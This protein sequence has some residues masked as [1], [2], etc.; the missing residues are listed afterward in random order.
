MVTPIAGQ[1]MSNTNTNAAQYT[2]TEY[3][4]QEQANDPFEDLTRDLGLSS[5]EIADMLMRTPSAA[6]S[7]Y[8]VQ[9]WRDHFEGRDLSSR[10][11]ISNF[12]NTNYNL[13][14]KPGWLRIN[15]EPQASAGSIF[16]DNDEKYIDQDFEVQVRL[17]ANN[18]NNNTAGFLYTQS[19]NYLSWFGFFVNSDDIQYLSSLSG[20]G[21]SGP[22]ANTSTAD[23]SSGLDLKINYTVSSA[24]VKYYYRVNSWANNTWMH[25]YTEST[26]ETTFDFGFYT[27]ANPGSGGMQVDLDYFFIDTEQEY[28][29]LNTLRDNVNDYDQV[30]SPWLT[31]AAVH[32]ASVS[33]DGNT[34]V[35]GGGYLLDT[36]LHIY[37]WDYLQRKYV[38]AWEAGSEVIT[39]DVYDI[40]FGDADNNRLQEVAAASADG[41]VYLFEQAHIYDPNT[42]L[43]SKYELVWQSDLI[44][45]QVS[46]VDF[47]DLDLD[48]ITD[49]VVGAWDK[50]VHIYEYTNHSGYPFA[51]AEHWIE[52]TE[53]W[54]SPEL[55]DAVMSVATGDFNNN[56]LPDFVVG[57]WSGHVYV[58]EN[59]GL[60]I[61]VQGTPTQLPWDNNYKMI[62]NSSDALRPLW[63]P[64]SK[65]AAGQ[66]DGTG[67][68][69]AVLLVWGQGSYVLQYTSSRGFYLEQLVKPYRF[70][71]TPDPYPLDNYAD[72]IEHDF[73]WNIYNTYSGSPVDEPKWG[74][75]NGNTNTASSGPPDGTYSIYS[76]SSTV[77]ASTV[78]NM[79]LHNEELAT[80]GNEDPDLFIMFP[81]SQYVQ[82]NRWTIAL[83]K[84][85]E[86]WYEVD[87]SDI[88]FTYGSSYQGK[89]I[90][91]DCD[92]LFAEQRMQSVKYVKLTLSEGSIEHRVDTLF[93]P[94]AAKPLTIASAVSIED[95]KLSTSDIS[96]N[97][98]VFG[99]SDGRF[100]SYKFEDDHSQYHFITGYTD[101][102][103]ASLI[104][105]YGVTIPNYLEV[106]DS[107][108]DDNY[109]LGVTVWDLSRTDKARV[110]PSWRYYADNPATT[111]YYNN[112]QFNGWG[113]VD[114]NDKVHSFSVR[115]I[116]ESDGSLELIINTNSSLDTDDKI[117]LFD[118][119]TGEEKTLYLGWLG[120]I[121]LSTLY[122][123]DINNYYSGGAVN[124]WLTH[125]MGDLNNDDTQYYG[126]ELITFP[127]HRDGRPFLTAGTTTIDQV[128]PRIWTRA[129]SFNKFVHYGGSEAD[130]SLLAYISSDTNASFISFLLNPTTYPSSYIYDLD[131]DNDNDI[132]VSNGHLAVLWNTGTPNNPQFTFDDNYFDEVNADLVG[133]QIF[134][135]QMWDY[136]LDGD[137]DV[138]FSYGKGDGD[139]IWGFDFFMNLGANIRGE[140]H[141]ER[142]I[143]IVEN[144]SRYGSLISNHYTLGSIVPSSSCE[145]AGLFESCTSAEAFWVYSPEND[146]TPGI[147]REEHMK[148]LVAEV[149]TQSSFVV[150]T[151][152]AIMKVEI[153]RYQDPPTSVNMGYAMTTSWSNDDQVEDWTRT[154]D[155]ADLDS[156]GNQ[157][158]IVGDFD[159]N[160]Y[161]FEHITNNTYKRAFKSH[162]L[163]HTVQ[164]TK[165][166]YL[167]EDLAGIE[168]NFTQ[169]VYD[170][171][172]FLVSGV[173]FNNDGHAGFV[174]TSGNTVYVFENIGYNDEVAL[175]MSFDIGDLFQGFTKFNPSTE[176]ITALAATYDF[177]GRGGMIAVAINNKLFL[178]QN[179]PVLGLVET[180]QMVENSPGYYN[181][182][183]NPHYYPSLGIEN[184]LFA[185]MNKDGITELWIGGY[186]GSSGGGFLVA[187]QADFSGNIYQSYEFPSSLTNNNPINTFVTSDI[188]LDGNLEMVVG[189]KYGVDIWEFETD[190]PL[191]A[192]WMD[193]ITSDT[194][195]AAGRV[196]PT[197]YTGILDVKQIAVGDS[198]AD[199][200]SELFLGHDER[201][202]LLEA[203]QDAQGNVHHVQMWQSD[204]HDK[205]VRSVKIADVNSNGWPE[206]IYA[207]R[208]GDVFALEITDV[209]QPQASANF[210]A[211]DRVEFNPY[212]TS[213][214]ISDNLLSDLMGDTT[215][216]LV[217]AR[218]DVGG[219]V[220]VYAYGNQTLLWSVADP[221]GGITKYV[222]LFKDPSGEKF[223]IGVS[224]KGIYKINS[225]GVI[226]GELTGNV[227]DVSAN[228][229]MAD[230]E[231]DGFDELVV[232][233]DYN[234]SNDLSGVVAIDLDNFTAVWSNEVVNQSTLH[235]FDL[236]R[237]TS[238]LNLYFSVR[239]G[240][241]TDYQRV[242]VL[243]GEGNVIIT[244]DETPNLNTDVRS[245]LA[246]FNGDG[247]LDLVTLA[248]DSSAGLTSV[249]ILRTDTF[250]EIFELEYPDLGSAVNGPLRPYA[251]DVNN[252]SIVDLVLPI[253]RYNTTAHVDQTLIPRVSYYTGTV[254]AIDVGTPVV[255]WERPIPDSLVNIET[256]SIAGNT[257]L[258]A[259]TENFGA[260]GI[261]LTG[262]DVF[263]T[264]GNLF[265]N[266]IDVEG[267]LLS[268]VT[269]SGSIFVSAFVGE[270]TR[271]VNYVT[272]RDYLP[273]DVALKLYSGEQT[274]TTIPVDVYNRGI[275]ELLVGMSNGSLYL[276]DFRR[277]YVWA[278]NTTPFTSLTATS[279][280]FAPDRFGF[281]LKTDQSNLLF[282]E[283]TNL[284]PSVNVTTPGPVVGNIHAFV[285][286]GESDVV[287]LQTKQDHGYML[288]LFNPLTKIY[289][290]NRTYAHQFTALEVG[291]FD[292][293]NPSQ[294]THIVGLDENGRA[295]L[296]ELPTVFLPGGEF[297]A[298]TVGR[299]TSMTAVANPSGLTSVY[300]GSD[301]GQILRYT[302][303]AEG[304]F[305]SDTIS[306]DTLPTVTSITVEITEVMYHPV[307]DNDDL[308]WVELFNPSDKAVKFDGWSL[309]VNSGDAVALSGTIPALGYYVIAH[310]A[311]EFQKKYGFRPDL[312]WDT[313]A[314]FSLLD[315]DSLA[316][317][318]N[319]GTVKSRVGWGGINYDSVAWNLVAS[320]VSLRRKSITVTN[321]ALAWGITTGA[322]DPSA[323][324]YHG[325]NLLITEINLYPYG[326]GYVQWLEIYNPT[327]RPVD[328]SGWSLYSNAFN[329]YMWLSGTVEPGDYFVVTRY[330]DAGLF[331]EYYGYAPDGVVT[332]TYF[333]LYPLLYLYGEIMELRNNYYMEVDSVGWYVF[334]TWWVLP[335]GTTMARTTLTDTNTVSDWSYTGTKGD[336]GFGPFDKPY[337]M[338]GVAQKNSTSNYVLMETEKRELFVAEDWNNTLGV[339]TDRTSSLVY[340]QGFG[341]T[342]VVNI[343]G[344]A[345]EIAIPI[346]NFIL[347]KD[348]NLED[349]ETHSFPSE[350]ASVQTWYVDQT[351]R[352]TLVFHLTN[353]EVWIADSAGRIINSLFDQSFYNPT[354][355]VMADDASLDLNK[356]ESEEHVS[357]TLDMSQFIA[358]GAVATPLAILL[359]NLTLVLVR[360]RRRNA[361]Q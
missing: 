35:I 299:W 361:D 2:M 338:L 275:Q 334:P 203:T 306:A 55:D 193:V 21:T 354:E 70:W 240:N 312:S 349:V 169:V 285:L 273:R 11:A 181:L 121:S 191:D 26:A 137:P 359:T 229:A 323:G 342:N 339:N 167:F 40:A 278:L 174:A 217:V 147:D 39:G 99:G 309:E 316:L 351:D 92:P 164:T 129:D 341:L 61:D 38:K 118:T 3:Q 263:W 154:L 132:V 235:L 335:V 321:D 96:G 216:E 149:D 206:L 238:N 319:L 180:F 353:G 20:V 86:T 195:Y 45:N 161:V 145:T 200:R 163:N 346:G 269:L 176:E 264:K 207:V 236:A 249:Q 162:D 159:N 44:D 7:S 253:A 242:F 289:F 344:S 111:P 329:Y 54:V 140:Y 93:Y 355:R 133:D 173:D 71:E 308:E 282:F 84:D 187:L 248:L 117:Q 4:P 10:W 103:G 201:V 102:T 89:T 139:T 295:M 239:A 222:E 30:W 260:F 17:T 73:T 348:L 101:L 37:R 288:S 305:E 146:P 197:A 315:V 199:V 77:N 56:G 219:G 12:Q 53:K 340:S 51:S 94:Y 175:L 247:I 142:N 252:D 108:E 270:L 294:L 331:E 32:S 112:S 41:R 183:G 322:G 158:V 301:K 66:L 357:Q 23:W 332:T 320:E 314:S 223:I 266:S 62:W 75:V 144:P 64:V 356:E 157:E 134:Q 211:E 237:S 345:S 58:F 213:T 226:Q 221:L 60:V 128:V 18:T 100:L 106:W 8:A 14:D 150:G 280:E 190:Q 5:D 202:T 82:A 97:K 36:E 90:A 186:N 184:L 258:V 241:F 124:E 336:P 290:W 245:A 172:N 360:N 116:Y 277:G 171:T 78:Y 130:S 85:L 333:G 325:S 293:E 152:P 310:N 298:P 63:K 256:V 251:L 135:P 267:D 166:P 1:E 50:R 119:T 343:D 22:L 141:W 170:H 234:S 179:D 28:Y 27:V 68:D 33:D 42:N 6:P 214:I 160:I 304:G 114:A 261:S 95:I 271:A 246:D 80:N 259:L 88:S 177:D 105:N 67:G 255:I 291:S 110:I 79:G 210:L 153:N 178:F 307:G 194:G 244:H 279:I 225:T 168:G 34:L 317:K 127:W 91:V 328:L 48:L 104:S 350:V 232:A 224:T 74:H 24:E 297:P 47:Y 188:D 330:Q 287:L 122:F 136:D 69:E 318:N 228:H 165:S 189:H 115:D 283:K 358:F 243:D 254:I 123:D 126:E 59:A 138:A 303:L 311:A 231:M 31:K 16:L 352:Q 296:V 76:P 131:G 274:V 198:D 98:I 284:N 313:V 220:E 205:E 120:T 143:Q 292:A 46:T 185:D 156:D 302:W 109:N 65:I 182:P 9:G 25:L 87:P 43:D 204:Y 327:S 286:N 125:S 208:G 155:I 196:D 52:M 107:Y 151:N 209:S 347:V 324:S 113:T 19:E 212:P 268:V 276:R 57:T 281:V 49:L 227:V 29:L 15:L 265:S 215:P 218:A 72:W 148:R 262:S 192:E 257:R 272:P 300:L 337:K 81:Y 83:G 13:A 230:I 233:Y 326:S 250:G